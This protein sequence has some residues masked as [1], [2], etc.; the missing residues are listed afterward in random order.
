MLLDQDQLL[1]QRGGLSYKVTFEEFR[2]SLALP[3]SGCNPL[4]DLLATLI[5]SIDGGAA[6]DES[7]TLSCSVDNGTGFSNPP[8]DLDGGSAFG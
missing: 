6:Q 7:I 2:E 5:E 8:Y 4:L 1:V 3:D